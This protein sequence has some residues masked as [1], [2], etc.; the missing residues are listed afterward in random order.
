[1]NSK[2]SPLKFF[3]SHVH[4]CNFLFENFYIV[5]GLNDFFLSAMLHIWVYCFKSKRKAAFIYIT[6]IY[7]NIFT[8]GCIQSLRQRNLWQITPSPKLEN[9]SLLQSINHTDISINHSKDESINILEKQ[10][11]TAQ[12]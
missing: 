7:V 12:K 2:Y 5:I 6:E 8:S 4:I 3:P 9:K 10:T 11:N 1:M